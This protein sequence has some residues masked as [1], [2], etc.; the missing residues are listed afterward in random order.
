MVFVKSKGYM[1]E[2][3]SDIWVTMWKILASNPK[4]ASDFVCEDEGTGE[5]WEY[6]GSEGSRHT[7]RHRRHPITKQRETFVVDLSEE[8]AAG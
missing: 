7:F 1:V 8:V 3:N 5:C 4:N 2:R 6:V